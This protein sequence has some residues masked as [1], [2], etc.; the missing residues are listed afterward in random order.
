MQTK[1]CK[2]VQD[3][4][5]L[6]IWYKIELRIKKDFDIVYV[7]PKHGGKDQKRVL[8]SSAKP[9]DVSCVST[10]CN[11]NG[12]CGHCRGRVNFLFLSAF[13]L[14]GRMKILPQCHDLSDSV[15]IHQGF[16][17]CRDLVVE[18]YEQNS[19]WWKCQDKSREMMDAFLEIGWVLSARHC[20]YPKT[21]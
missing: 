5:W 15:V 12:I 21:R 8:I 1:K 19:S 7:V 2:H 18:F 20:G 14:D 16:F 6:F 11:N 10:T 4:E 3:G 13:C 17:V 9:W